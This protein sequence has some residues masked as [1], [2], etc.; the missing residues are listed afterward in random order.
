ME[1]LNKTR[2]ITMSNGVY[3]SPFLIAI[4][5][6]GFLTITF[7]L[8]YA[9]NIVGIEIFIGI[10]GVV[11]TII[12]F[13]FSV[14]ITQTESI[15]INQS[16]FN[17][18]ATIIFQVIHKKGEISYLSGGRD[19]RGHRNSHGCKSGCPRP[20]GRFSVKYRLRQGS[21]QTKRVC[22]KNL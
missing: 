16:K 7:S 22:Q 11:A 13:L 2:R 8:L 15:F 5:I 10:G 12:C 4:I 3:R 18:I 9:T 1:I 6:C 20:E 14:K 19:P 17:S 21:G